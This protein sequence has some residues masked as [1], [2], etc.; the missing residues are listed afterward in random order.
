M[1]KNVIFDLGRVM[2]RY[3]PEEYLTALGFDKDK[4]KYIMD[5]VFNTKMWVEMDRGTYSF[6]QAI[7]IFS[8]QE[9]ALAGEIAEILHCDKFFPIF[10]IMQESLDFY[11]EVKSSGYKIYILSNY[12][13]E[14][15]AYVRDRND[16]FNMADGIVVSAHI[17][18]VKPD[19][20]IFLYIRDKYALIPSET[21]FIDDSKANIDAAEALGFRTILFTDI[22]DCRSSFDKITAEK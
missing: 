11:T 3:E 17:N 8:K 13:A 9:P 18:M 1:I 4:T 15:F 16:F 2:I 20:E 22:K 7:D 6:A 19:D 5:H 10:T 21:I 14:G 12:S